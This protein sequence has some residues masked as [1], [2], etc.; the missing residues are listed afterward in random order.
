MGLSAEQQSIV[1]HS[2]EQHAKVLA[3]AG[4]GKSHTMVERAAYLVEAKRVDPN[5]IIVVMFNR[6]AM[7]EFEGRL[8]KRLGKRN[9]PDSVTFHQMGGQC[10]KWLVSGGFVENWK[11]EPEPTRAQYF[12][13]DVIGPACRKY[14]YKY[15]RIVA[16]AFLGFID[17]VKS[18]LATPQEVWEAG[19]WDSH[20]EWFVGMYPVFE[21]AR[22]KKKLR[23]F[24]DLIYDPVVAMAQSPEAAAH[25]ANRFRHIII[26]EFQDICE[27]QYVMMRYVAGDKAKVMVV[28]D[29]DQ[30][31]YTWRG[32]KPSY[33]LRGFEEDFEDCLTYR[34]TR[35]WRY[36]HVLSCAANYVITHNTDRADKLCISSDST[37]ATKLMLQ[38]EDVDG[39]ALIKVVEA[40]LGAGRQLDEIAILVRT[41]SRSYGS[42]FAM[43]ERG[44]PFR[45]EGGDNVSVLDNPWVSALLSWMEVADGRFAKRPYAG[46]P[47]GGSV[48]KMRKLLGTPPL[49]ISYEGMKDLSTKVLLEPD[50]IGA[51][52]A[53]VA[54]GLT[55]QE[56]HL[57]ARVYK[58]A[59]VWREVRALSQERTHSPMV[60][61]SLLLER[62]EVYESI[63]SFSRN[64]DD[65]EEQMRLVEAFVRY[66]QSTNFT[67]LSEFLNHIDDLRSFSERAKRSTVA[68]HV[69]S[70]HKSKG[71]EWPCVMMIG[72][73]EGGFPHKP[74]KQ[75]AGVNEAERIE[76]ERRLFYVAMTRAR[77]QLCLFSPPDAE[78]H[79]WLRA[80]RTGSPDNLPADGKTASRFLYET[81]LMLADTLPAMIDQ[82]RQIKAANPEVYNAYLAELGVK[83]RARS[84]TEAATA[85]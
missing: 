36:G 72:L 7:E 24:S 70:V 4:S 80:G 64:A 47:D 81:N 28:G 84:I 19:D 38:W 54:S 18:D 8:I 63:Q 67:R 76:D 62:L 35:T 42:Q 2:V 61:I 73:H 33:I 69:T 43:L 37:P 85:N 20:Y 53:F 71:L 46:E 41:Y 79:T 17:R 50:G 31:I 39:K 58:R 15:P 66:I 10:L 30:T 14:G 77:E 26:D 9:T 11:F 57:S 78:L 25:V 75:S 1:L 51:F 23:F 21:Q 48:F 65:A 3:V 83:G 12:C 40:W 34:L 44:I 5:H 29:D 6:T 56:G 22:A 74:R 27:A 55:A 45:L 82:P 49:G 59:K 13:A 60:M 52:N 68:V 32:A 16:D